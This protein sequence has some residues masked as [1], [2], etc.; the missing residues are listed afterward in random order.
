MKIVLQKS[1]R[2]RCVLVEGKVA[3]AEKRVAEHAAVV[4]AADR[5][6]AGLEAQTEQLCDASAQGP[7]LGLSPVVGRRLGRIC[8]ELG[9][10][11]LEKNRIVQLTNEGERVA[12]STEPRVFVPQLGAWLLFWSEDPLLPQPLLRV[13]PG[14]ELSAHEERQAGGARNGEGKRRFEMVPEVIAKTCDERGER[15]PLELPAAKDG[16]PIRIVAIERKVQPLGV[17]GVLSLELSFEP[18]VAAAS[19]R[20]QGTLAGKGIDRALPAP[21]GHDHASVWLSLLR[22]NGA[23]DWWNPRSGKLRMSFKALSDDARTSFRLRMPFKTPEIPGLGRFDDTSVDGVP[24]E[25]VSAGDAQRWFDWLLALR[26]ERTQ[27][28]DVFATNVAELQALF[29]GFSLRPPIQREFA[30]GLRGTERPRPAYW[31]LQAPMDLEGG[32]A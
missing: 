20:L 29:P 9:L 21:S 11:R 10:L 32:V 4:W 30:Q 8:E 15:P 19:L 6:R 7:L 25:P 18:E 23:E 3:F 31:N 12:A 14:K 28:P 1:L 24:L 22:S 26:S 5:L 2:V 13:E 17:E 16:A 27:W